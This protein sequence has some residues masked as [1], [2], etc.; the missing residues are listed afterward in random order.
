M[1]ASSLFLGASVPMGNVMSFTNTH[2][3]PWDDLVVSILSVNQYSLERTYE[4]M[5]QL[6][7][8]GITNPSNLTRWGLSEIEERLRSA[9]CDRGEFMTR[10]FGERLAAL[11]L[12]VRARGIDECE[13]ILA[14]RNAKAIEG[15]LMPVK[16]IGPVVLRNF[17]MLR[18]ISGSG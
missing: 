6:R 16:G 11:G 10:L 15:L 4:S 2:D 18:N 5:P 1:R 12:L 7:E 8:Q 3:S 9:G 13:R 14:G 17:F